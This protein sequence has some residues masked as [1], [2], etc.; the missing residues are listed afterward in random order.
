M[1]VLEAARGLCSIDLPQKELT[2]SVTGNKK[3]NQSS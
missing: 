3:Y 1:V 2:S